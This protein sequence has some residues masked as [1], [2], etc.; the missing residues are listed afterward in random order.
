MTR[1]L[2]W[3]FL[4]AFA[5]LS[6]Y[7]VLVLRFNLFPMFNPMLTPLTN[8]LGFGFALL[9]ASQR[10]N[11]RAALTLFVV[12][13][14]IS[15][16]YESLGVATG[17]V[18]G[19]YHYTE[20]LGP[21]FLGLVPYLIPAAWFMMMYPS[22]VIAERIAPRGEGWK[23]A[24]IVAALG[25]IIMTAWDVVM[26]PMMVRGGHWV[27]DVKGA[28]FGIPL[29]NYWGWWLTMFSVFLVNWLIASRNGE[30]AK[31]WTERSR[32]LKDDR[33]AVISYTITALSGILACLDPDIVSELGGAA[34]AGF[35]AMCPWAL[36]GWIRAGE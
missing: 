3:I 32:R 2:M 20:K 18:Y 21:K 23:R 19:P 35:F 4:I 12:S 26:D 1:K 22:L 36:M 14:V 11:W 17:L 24:L 34:L 10:W 28:Y 7:N 31:A 5:L 15:L 25:G 8:L 16:A 13:F 6:A 30:Q 29:Q 33:L 9:H 27:W